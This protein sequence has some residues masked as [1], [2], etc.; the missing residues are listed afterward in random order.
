MSLLQVYFASFSIS[1]KNPHLSNENELQIVTVGKLIE[2]STDARES[3]NVWDEDSF[4]PSLKK[5]EFRALH[6][7]YSTF[8]ACKEQA[9]EYLV[10]LLLLLLVLS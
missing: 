4:H 3:T 2:E 9:I 5:I 1:L 7:I 6:S 10:V 8:F